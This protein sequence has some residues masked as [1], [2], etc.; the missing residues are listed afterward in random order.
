MNSQED[1]VFFTSIINEIRLDPFSKAESLGYDRVTLKKEMPWLEDTYP[2]YAIDTFLNLKAAAHNSA[3]EDISEPDLTPEH[4]YLNTDE[5][6][7]VITFLNF[8][9]S[10]DAFKIIIENIFKQELNPERVSPLRLLSTDFQL[11]GIS[12]SAG[13]ETIDDY[14]RN[15][16]FITIC[17]GSSQLKSEAQLQTMVNQVRW[18]PYTLRH[19]YEIS[20]A[21]FSDIATNIFQE[22]P[23]IYPP[24]M[25]NTSLQKSAKIYSRQLINI[26]RDPSLNLS[27]DPFIR[28]TNMGYNGSDVSESHVL[29]IH[30]LNDSSDH[31]VNTAFSYLIRK[32][33]K[34]TLENRVLFAGSASESGIGITFFP[35]R[36]RIKF[37]STSLNAGTTNFEQEDSK[38]SDIYSVI[39]SDKNN[40]SVY[41]TGEEC[42]GASVTIYSKPDNTVV[43]RFFTDNAGRFITKIINNQD[44]RFE[45]EYNDIIKI[46][47]LRINKSL[48]LPVQIP[49]SIPQ[50]AN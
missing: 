18:Q 12:V 45:I 10:R 35:Y 23:N 33:L 21:E 25:S 44:Y 14:W 4:D 47:N 42:K 16:Y 36:E 2:P 26:D 19:Y 22:W 39:Y 48:F 27:N 15:A 1:L 5:T 9:S 32:E 17:F 41:T 34:S 8:L 29:R 28:A 43:N 40:N 3:N 30:G 20:D 11:M 38:Y 7:G 24:L 49:S 50:T 31:I 37:I 46:L 13:T 6:G